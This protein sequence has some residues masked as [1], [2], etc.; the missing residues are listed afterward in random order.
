MKRLATAARAMMEYCIVDRYND[1]LYWYAVVL[2]D[3]VFGV[4]DLSRRLCVRV[5]FGWCLLE[6]ED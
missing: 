6:P 5:Q 4:I 3:V 1:R 2:D